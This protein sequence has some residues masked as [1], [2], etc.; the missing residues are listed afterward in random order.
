MKVAD[1]FRVFVI[2]TTPNGEDRCLLRLSW[3]FVADEKSARYQLVV[4]QKLDGKNDGGV[5]TG[6]DCAND[7]PEVYQPGKSKAALAASA[8]K[9]GAWYTLTR[10]IGYEVAFSERG[11]AMDTWVLPKGAKVLLLDERLER[12]DTVWVKCSLDVTRERD[13]KQWKP[14][15][16]SLDGFFYAKIPPANLEI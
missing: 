13:T 7:H 3:R 4:L 8:L 10:T 9:A 1:E 16:S 15:I 6:G 2:I 14:E 5:I 12:D 11:Q